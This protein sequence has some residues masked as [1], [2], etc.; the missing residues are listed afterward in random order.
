MKP[1]IDY[2]GVTVTFYCTD[3]KGN[4]AFH[5]RS[6]KCRDEQGHWDC[7]GGTLEFG[8]SFEEGVLREVAEEY[9][10]KGSILQQLPPMNRIRMNNGVATHWV[11]LAFIIKVNPKEVR[12]NEPAAMD[13]IGW[14][15]LDNLPQPLHST[16]PLR[17]KEQAEYFKPFLTPQP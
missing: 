14:F 2:I 4:W 10:C 8:E 5:K 1:G 12:I 9:G 7:G 15:T 16:I 11:S 17:L 3:G 6:Q 13:D